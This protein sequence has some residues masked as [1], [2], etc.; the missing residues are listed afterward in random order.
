MAQRRR[1]QPG[2]LKLRSSFAPQ[3][4]HRHCPRS[5]PGVGLLERALRRLDLGGSAANPTDRHWPSMCLVI[6]SGY[7]FR[8]LQIY[9]KL[10]SIHINRSHGDCK[11]RC[12]EASPSAT[13]AALAG[14]AT[15]LFAA[16]PRLPDSEM[17]IVIII[18]TSI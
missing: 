18:Q 7:L 11:H 13:L 2:E 5:R 17:I 12:Q 8:M 14:N 9:L 10:P 4:T 16:P 15:H 3:V 1:T 6:I